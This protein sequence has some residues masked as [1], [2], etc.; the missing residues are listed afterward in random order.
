MS[1]NRTSYRASVHPADLEAQPNG[2][3]DDAQS[4]MLDFEPVQPKQF[5]EFG[6]PAPLGLS[7]FALTT[8]VLSL[9]NMQSRGVTDP[10]IAIGLCMF[11]VFLVNISLRVWR[12]GSI[13][14][15]NVGTCTRKYI[16]CADFHLLL[17]ILDEFRNDIYPMVQHRHGD[18][19]RQ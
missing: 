3:R 2:I 14:G 4:I 19:L 16:Q 13:H 18:R 10:N 9:I 17:R 7:A 5:R 1:G 8:S 15:G 11:F 6:D 12:S